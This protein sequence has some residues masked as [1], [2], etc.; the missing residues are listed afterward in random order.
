MNLDPTIGSEIA[1]TRPA[2]VISNDIGNQYSMRVIVAPIT[3]SRSERTYP[4]E[5]VLEPGEAGLERTSKVLLDQIRTLDK[6][7][8]GRQLGALSAESMLKI[9][10]AI[11]LSL[12]LTGCLNQPE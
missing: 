8:L 12:A 2:V 4:F 3:S 6:R 9:D 11:H 7:R 10:R 1:K 5:V